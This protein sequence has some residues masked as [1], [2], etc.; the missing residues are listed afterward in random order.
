MGSAAASPESPVR[1]A[2]R[3]PLRAVALYAWYYTVAFAAYYWL[4]GDLHA[5]VGAAL[6]VFLLV[7]RVVVARHT[8]PRRVTASAS[9]DAG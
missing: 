9:P 8:S 2:E 3:S 1:R 6:I 5:A 4:R 7:G